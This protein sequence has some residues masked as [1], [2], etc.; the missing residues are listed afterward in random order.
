MGTWMRT[1]CKMWLSTIS[2]ASLGEL[3][4]WCLVTSRSPHW[5]SLREVPAGH[6][7]VVW[8]WGQ[9]T[10]I[11]IYCIFLY[12]K[13][14]RKDAQLS[15]L[16]KACNISAYLQTHPHIYVCMYVMSCHVMS[17]CMYVC[18]HIYN[19]HTYTYVY[20]GKRTHT[21]SR[22]PVYIYIYIYI[23]IFNLDAH[24]YSHL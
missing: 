24:V 13:D 8:S 12:R 3:I 14:E 10:I 15:F 16:L 4:P 1:I 2:I 23:Y 6:L 19:M 17:V 18:I 11:Y 22:V 7:P 5:S 21:H 20:K 9:S